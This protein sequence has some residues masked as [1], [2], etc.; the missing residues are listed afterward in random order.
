MKK[1]MALTALVAVILTVC[2]AGCS[3][4]Q[5]ESTA[6]P[7]PSGSGT[8]SVPATTQNPV[9]EQTTKEAGT[10]A[11]PTTEV[12]EVKEKKPLIIASSNCRTLN[13]YL[14]NA[15]EDDFHIFTG[16]RLYR[17]FPEGADS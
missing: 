11:A 7:V 9:P 16:T 3:S 12:P 5:N 10:T 1:I 8:P 15:D 13:P 6:Q 14:A 17:F 2:L 4:G